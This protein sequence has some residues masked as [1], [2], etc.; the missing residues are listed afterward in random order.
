MVD[1]GNGGRSSVDES[2]RTAMEKWPNVPA[3]HGW[4]SLDQQGRW[5]LRGEPIT[6]PGLVAFIDRNYECDEAGRWF[7]QNGPQRGYVRLEYTPWVLHVDASGALRTHTGREVRQ[8]AG[9]WID[10]EGNLLLQID[11]GVGLVDPDSLAA[12]SEWL[13]DAAGEP[14]DPERIETLANGSGDDTGLFI[15]FAGARVPLGHIERERVAERFGF[16]ADPQ[17]V[18]AGA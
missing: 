13:V 2:V 10:D 12:V 7:F 15:A 16:V 9:A 6:H 8:L 11:A 4:L 14:V 5:R 17:P 18:E 1:P 3:V